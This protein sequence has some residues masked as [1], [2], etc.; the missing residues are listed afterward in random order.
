MCSYIIK[1]K[2][3]YIEHGLKVKFYKNEIE[4]DRNNLESDEKKFKL[5]SL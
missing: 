5:N 2:D 3:E 4:P 1:S